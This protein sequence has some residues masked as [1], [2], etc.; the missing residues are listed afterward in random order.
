ML[1]FRLSWYHIPNISLW[2][3]VGIGALWLWNFSYASPT[4]FVPSSWGIF[5]YKL[6]K[7]IDTRI[8]K[9]F[10][11]DFPLYPMSRDQFSIFGF[12]HV[13][14]VFGRSWLTNIV[15]FSGPWTNS[16]RR[17]WDLFLAKHKLQ[18]RI[19]SEVDEGTTGNAECSV[20]RQHESSHRKSDKVGCANGLGVIHRTV[21]FL[22]SRKWS[23]GG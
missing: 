2:W 11:L 21:A 19:T 10:R 15:L 7:S 18:T 23:H 16:W 22:F 3:C 8:V 13:V 1:L 4:M 14:E 5:V 9:S 12:D 6:E 20:E 17:E